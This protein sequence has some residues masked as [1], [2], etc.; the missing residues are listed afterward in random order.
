MIALQ[1]FG[2]RKEFLDEVHPQ[3][4]QPKSDHNVYTLGSI[5]DLNVVLTCLR[6]GVYEATPATAAVT[7]LKS[8][9]QN[10]R[11]GL[12]V[13]I[14]GG[15]REE[16]PDIRLGDI[17]PPPILLK[18][19]AQME[20]DYM[21]GWHSL[22][23][24]MA[25]KLHKEGI[26]KKFP[27]SSKDQL[28]QSA[29]DHPHIHYGFIASGSQ[30]MKDAKARDSIA[31]GRN[32]LCFEMEAAGLMD[33]IPSLIRT[34]FVGREEEINTIDGLL[35]QIQGPSKI[36][37]CGLGGV[38]KIQI[39]LEL[40]YRT[41]ERDPNSPYS[42]FHVQACMNRAQ[43]VGMQGLKPAEAKDRVKSYLSQ[44]HDMDMWLV[45]LPLPIIQAAAYTNSND[46]WVSDYNTLLQEQEPDVTDLL[47][48]DF[49]DD[50]RYQESQ[51]P[52]ATTWLISFQK[53]QE[54][55]QLAADYLSFMA[56]DKLEAIGLLKGFAFV[57]EQVQGVGEDDPG[58]STLVSVSDLLSTHWD[59]GRLK[60][61]KELGVQVLE[62]CKRILGPEHPDALKSMANLASIHQNRGQLKEAEELEVR[63]L[64][65]QI[66]KAPVEQK[67]FYVLKISRKGILQP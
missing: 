1:S 57:S 31:Q 58:I 60:E 18:A 44:G 63:V 61:A 15:S 50:G 30:V 22:R 21:L 23:E 66:F 42:G 2:S 48:E 27:R 12:M 56:Y 46:L 19:I 28:F 49:G 24:I 17:V 33:E 65:I 55:N 67:V 16:I 37:I 6:A 38:G 59:L 11:F 26:R 3:L 45:F 51:N 35:Q 29:Y 39:A 40:A 20:S 36:A 52:V 13:G 14:G 10:I 7:C 8:S 47:N 43:L 62:N 54:L 41:R 25:S 53:I 9:Y 34:E 32:T 64:E 4:A 5:G